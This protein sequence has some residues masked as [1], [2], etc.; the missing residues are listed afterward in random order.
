[1][2]EGGEEI[3]RIE[4]D[5]RLAVDCILGGE[6]GRTLLMST[7]NSFQPDETEGRQGRIERIRLS[8]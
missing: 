3:E 8:A 1:V 7:A 6:D 5:G 2:R 4:L